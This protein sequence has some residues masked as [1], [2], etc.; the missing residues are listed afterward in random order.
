M[1]KILK[2][3]TISF[4]LFLILVPSSYA[5]DL[6]SMDKV[7]IYNQLRES[8]NVS[9]N[10][11]D[12]LNYEIIQVIEGG[13]DYDLI[14]EWIEEYDF[15]DLNRNIKNINLAIDSNQ[16]LEE[17]LQSIKIIIHLKFLIN[18]ELNIILKRPL[19]KKFG[20]LFLRTGITMVLMKL[21]Y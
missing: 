15:D 14:I 11:I 7:E 20:C 10:E 13:V 1:E 5:N 2:I 17:I 9:T 3:L 4:L 12:D 18:I 8:Y 19:Q 16:P 21:K 6:D